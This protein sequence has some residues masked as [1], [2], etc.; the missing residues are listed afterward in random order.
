M[1]EGEQAAVGIEMIGRDERKAESNGQECLSLSRT[2]P[3]G[4][5]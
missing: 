4:H 2:R 1:R 3:L 5:R